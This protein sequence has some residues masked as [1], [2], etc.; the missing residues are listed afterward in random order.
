M[1]TRG[2]RSNQV[3]G[4]VNF[5]V[6]DSDYKN[7]GEG[8]MF[9]RLVVAELKP[10]TAKEEAWS[11]CC[12]GDN[13]C[14]Y[15]EQFLGDDVNPDLSEEDL[16]KLEESP[17]ELLHFPRFPGRHANYDPEKQFLLDPYTS[18]PYLCIM[19]VGSTGWSGWHQGRQEYF[20]C[21]FENLTDEGKNLYQMIEKL[22]ENKGQ[23]YL[24]TWLDT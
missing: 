3:R 2:R 14:Y 10:Q 16:G 5:P 8:G 15:D 13:F 1:K 9:V 18:L 20:R 24:Q 7:T 22:Y 23:I 17:A 6:N 19:T 4:W 11:V 12:G 21:R